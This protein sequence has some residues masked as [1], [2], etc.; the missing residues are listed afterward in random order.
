MVRTA[1]AVCVA[2]AAIAVHASVT[3]REV[4]YKDGTPKIR[5]ELNEQGR[6]EGEYL[7]YHRN[8]VV[9]TH[10]TYRGGKRVGLWVHADERGFIC[11]Y[12]DIT[13][14]GEVHAIRTR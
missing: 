2:A 13:R 6:A 3:V 4:A 11:G 8:G 10:G 12:E 9:R 7:S 1:G 14:R 5:M